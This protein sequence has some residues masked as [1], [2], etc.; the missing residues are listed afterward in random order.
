MRNSWQLNYHWRPSPSE[1]KP[2]A[3]QLLTY[4]HRMRAIGRPEN[5]EQGGEMY[6]HGA[7]SNI[8]RARNFLVGLAFYEPFEDLVLPAG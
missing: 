1:A 7:F 6:L 5:P 8:Q 4:R 3:N 2:S